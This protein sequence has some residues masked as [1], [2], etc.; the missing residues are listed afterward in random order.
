MMPPVL[1]CPCSN[2]CEAP[3]VQVAQSDK[4]PSHTLTLHL[5]T[6]ISTQPRTPLPN[7]PKMWPSSCATD[8]QVRPFRNVDNPTPYP[9][10]FS[11]KAPTYATPTTPFVGGLRAGG[12]VGVGDGSGGCRCCGGS[13]GGGGWD[14][15]GG[16]AVGEKVPHGDIGRVVLAPAA[17]NVGSSAC[18]QGERGARFFGKGVG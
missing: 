4:L 15:W 10:S 6:Q 12:S 5:L 9:P 3:T 7:P 17:G 11:H 8:S 14:Y 16:V 18:R 13:S 1:P 2:E